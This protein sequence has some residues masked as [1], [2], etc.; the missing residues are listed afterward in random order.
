MSEPK[1]KPAPV[2]CFCGA[3]E[4]ELMDIGT[5]SVELDGEKVPPFPYAEAWMAAAGTAELHACRPCFE[6]RKDCFGGW[7]PDVDGSLVDLW[8][9]KY[10]IIAKLSSGF[11][12]AAHKNGPAIIGPDSISVIDVHYEDSDAMQKIKREASDKFR[13]WAWPQLVGQFYP[14]NPEPS[15]RP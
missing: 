12:L 4:V 14:A 15:A 9:T 13:E 8:G 2:C 11:V 7:V 6:A 1:S 5:P 3:A 10:P